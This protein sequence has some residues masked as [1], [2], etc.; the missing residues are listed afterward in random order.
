MAV[1]SI[2]F[3]RTSVAGRVPT[4]LEAGQIA[5]NIT[6][7]VMFLGD[8]SNNITDVSGNVTTGVTGKGFFAS[9]MDV[10]TAVAS[11]NSYTDT[12]I[13]NLIASAPAVLDT[14][15]E[16]A[17]ALG[18][19][20]NFATTITTSISNVQSNLTSE[21][22][23]AT[24]AEAANASGIAQNVSDIATNAADIATNVSDIATNAAAIAA[25][26][27]DI[28]TNASDIATNASDIAT[29]AAAIST[30]ERTEGKERREKL[31]NQTYRYK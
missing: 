11:A 1:N 10:S 22:A 6:D 5:F 13:S 23:R 17:A 30:E 31:R 3:L 9:D 20:P 15:N 28:A 26:A 21:I 19:D 24:A 25:N 7:K 12:Q 18:D 4:Q 2:Q 14:L 27:A 16:L 8:G 29:N